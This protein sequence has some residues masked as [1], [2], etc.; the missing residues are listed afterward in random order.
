MTS[1]ETTKRRIDRVETFYACIGTA[2]TVEFRH[3]TPESSRHLA[4]ELARKAG[5][6]LA[7][8]E[9]VALLDAVAGRRGWLASEIEKL[10]LF[11]KW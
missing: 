4:Q 8:L 11:C 7:G 5:L 10:S 1:W 6:K 9:L 3:F 2:A